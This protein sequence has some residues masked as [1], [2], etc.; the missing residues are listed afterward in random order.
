MNLFFAAILLSCFN[1]W[2]MNKKMK[3]ISGNLEYILIG[4]PLFCFDVGVMFVV[5]LFL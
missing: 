5:M 2:Y 4:L 1:F 3:D